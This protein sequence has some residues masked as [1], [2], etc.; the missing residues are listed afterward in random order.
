[1]HPSASVI[2]FTVLSG[3]GYGILFM[4][5][6]GAAIRLLPPDRIFAFVAFGLSL[7]FIT[8]GL[9][10][11]M[12]HLGRPERAWRAT[13]QWRSSWLS[14]E[15]LLALITYM[16]TAP[17]AVSWAFFGYNTG[18]I[19]VFGAI[20]G[21]LAVATVF[22]TGRIYSTLRPIRQWNSF[23]VTPS[24]LVIA[25][26][27]GALWVNA[28]LQLRGL[29][30][31][32]VAAIA[33]GAALVGMALKIGYWRHADT[34]EARSTAESATGLGGLGRVRLLE[35]PHTQE[36][37]LLREM[38][39]RVARKH[40]WRLRRISLSLGFFVP[41]VLAGLTIA[42]T[43]RL[44]AGVALTAAISGLIGI[45]IERWLFFAEAKHTVTL[46]YGAERT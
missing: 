8:I 10:S 9:L 45:L 34:G 33:A 24:Y 32:T 22:A 7:G 17:F 40:S 31:P 26:M 2:I 38:G 35:A 6:Y 25:L 21:L 36:N 41:F 28:I 23:W 42:V 27:S 1:M 39:Y 43:G 5:G 16:P 30:R 18:F 37:Y 19:A 29:P 15:G 4:L 20:A 46:Y 3:T 12:L 14:R 11:S 44:A 13:S